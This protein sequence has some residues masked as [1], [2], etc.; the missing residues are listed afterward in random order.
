MP[1]GDCSDGDPARFYERLDTSDLARLG[2]PHGLNS[3][4][5][6]PVIR[7]LLAGGTGRASSPWRKAAPSITCA[8]A[9]ESGTWT[10]SSA[11]PQTRACRGCSAA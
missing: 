8:A 6:S 5:S 10:S 11:S 1:H 7:T 3:M 2:A 4:R 9:G